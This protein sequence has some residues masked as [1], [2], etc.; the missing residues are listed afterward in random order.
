MRGRG[1]VDVGGRSTGGRVARGRS[2][3]GGVFVVR[4]GV[5]GV[6]VGVVVVGLGVGLLPGLAPGVSGS[7]AAVVKPEVPLVGSVVHPVVAGFGVGP[8]W[9]GRVGVA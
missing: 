1:V 7:A 2:G 3:W 8:L 4:P 6:L 5:G 9:W